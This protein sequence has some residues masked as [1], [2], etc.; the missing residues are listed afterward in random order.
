MFKSKQFLQWIILFVSYLPSYVVW[1]KVKLREINQICDNYKK[2]DAVR[3]PPPILT[4]DPVSMGAELKDPLIACPLTW[5]QNHLRHRTNKTLQECF[6]TDLRPL[7]QLCACV[8]DLQF[9][10]DNVIFGS[11]LLTV[12]QLLVS[13]GPRCPERTLLWSSAP[14]FCCVCSVEAAPFVVSSVCPDIGG[15]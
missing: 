12:F 3:P 6:H 4:S 7:F 15:P 2:S 5:K 13:V 14:C 11:K 9:C 1:S 10:L 8:L